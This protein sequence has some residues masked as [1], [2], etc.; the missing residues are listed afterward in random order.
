MPVQCLCAGVTMPGGASLTS[1]RNVASR[2][3]DRILQAASIAF[4]RLEARW[5]ST[6]A[7]RATE[8][9]LV[10][11][12]VAVLTLVELARRGWLPDGLRGVVPR[13]HFVAVSV[14]FSF[15]LVARGGGAR[16]RLRARAVGRR[17]CW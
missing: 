2:A 16:L 8:T 17:F 9:T 4:D 1:E 3:T 13:S 5:E 14:V 11:I 12:F 6:T 10:V 7:R 15:L